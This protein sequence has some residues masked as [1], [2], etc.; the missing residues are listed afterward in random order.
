MEQQTVKVKEEVGRGTSGGPYVYV[1]EG[2]ELVHVSDYAV[3]KLQG[4][5]SDEVIY[6]IPTYKVAGKILYCFGF[7][8]SGGEFM[9]RCK[10][11]DFEDGRP[12]RYEFYGLLAERIHE[13]RN[14]E[15]RV[16][17]PVLAAL[18]VQF[19]QLLIP[20]I[21]EIT[22][23]ERIRGFSISFMGHQARLE[24]AVRNYEVYY[25]TFMSL[26]EDKSRTISFKVTRR[27]VHQL[28]VLKLLCEALQISKFKGHDYEGKPYWWIEQGSELATCIGE[29]C[30][31]EMTF[32]LEYQPSK[33]AHMAGMFVGNRVPIRPDIVAVKG[34]FERTRDF[35]DSKNPIDLI[36]ECKEDPFD[37]WKSEIE[38]Q[39][40]PY[41]ETF[42][43]NNFIIVSLEPIPD[44]AKRILQSRGMKVI[45]NLKPNSETIRMLHNTIRE[46][47]SNFW[48]P[49]SRTQDK[50]GV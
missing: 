19:K 14:L 48:S 29:T 28:W 1:V 32:W 22:E 4:K 27:W 8:R 18:L 20:M 6:E 13:I 43:P 15:F 34:H 40:L 10:I 41:Q 11:E 33:G 17:D 25:F 3:K 37:N 45:D 31:G 44:A 26:P 7:S 24:N 39:I 49:K 38:S 30:F 50:T 5:Y 46:P 47:G 36:I 23:Y 21:H 16:Q 42:K 9:G 2:N 12:R 35:V